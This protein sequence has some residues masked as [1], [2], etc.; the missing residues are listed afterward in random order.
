MHER[1]FEQFDQ[2]PPGDDLQAAEYVLG[3]QPADERRRSEAR[4]AAEPAF[5]VLVTAWEQR[6][7]ALIAEIAPVA[8]PARR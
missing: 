5:A 1:D 4:I 6:F 8:V 2:D 7:A 3:V